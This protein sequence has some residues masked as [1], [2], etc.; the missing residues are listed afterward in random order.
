[1]EIINKTKKPEIK[2]NKEELRSLMTAF[3]EK[4]KL[5]KELA[6]DCG[7]RVILK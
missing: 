6:K 4:T 3:T 7:E 1:M 2:N 5:A